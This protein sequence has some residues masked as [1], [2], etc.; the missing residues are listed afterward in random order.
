MG[1]YFISYF[2]DLYHISVVCATRCALNFT[3][4]LPLDIYRIFMVFA[5]SH[6]SHIYGLCNATYINFKCFLLHDTQQDLRGFCNATYFAYL[7]FLPRSQITY[8]CKECFAVSQFSLVCLALF[9]QYVAR[10]RNRSA[11][12]YLQIESARECVN[13]YRFAYKIQPFHRPTLA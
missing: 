6:K 9:F 13:V 2:R 5:T 12:C 1:L 11:I 7:R 10:C 8:P 3:C 4:F